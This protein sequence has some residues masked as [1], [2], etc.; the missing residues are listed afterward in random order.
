MNYYYYF[1]ADYSGM[2]Y[3]FKLK[4]ENGSNYLFIK[5]IP[6]ND[7][8][9][10]GCERI[11]RILRKRNMNEVDYMQ[12]K[13]QC[14]LRTVTGIA[15]FSF[16]PT[17]IRHHSTCAI[18]LHF[19]ASPMDNGNCVF[20]IDILYYDGWWYAMM[21][22]RDIVVSSPRYHNHFSHCRGMCAAVNDNIKRLTGILLLFLLTRVCFIVPMTFNASPLTS[23]DHPLQ[24]C[25]TQYFYGR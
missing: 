24:C 17:N 6:L 13:N 1:T 2:I 10:L 21:I 5:Q 4:S 20:L 12:M 19:C 18:E 15:L 7:D 22:V 3:D 23:I 16:Y 14:R 25:I 9:I 8:V 11:L